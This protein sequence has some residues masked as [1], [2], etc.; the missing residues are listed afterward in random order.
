MFQGIHHAAI[1]SKDIEK[2]LPLFKALG[3]NKT[4]VDTIIAG[5]EA[6][7]LGLLGVDQARSVFL[8]KDD[9]TNGMVEI[10]EFQTRDGQPL[11][12]KSPYPCGLTG[13]S[14]QVADIQKAYDELGAAGVQFLM[15]P[16]RISLPG[17][18]DAKFGVFFGPDGFALEVFEKL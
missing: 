9:L 17:F 7:K 15:P 10:L 1:V 2:S 4:I 6:K 12:E 5:E 11:G 8:A 18:G 3:F 13:L 14:F 16:H